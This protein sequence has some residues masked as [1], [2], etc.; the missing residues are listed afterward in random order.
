MNGLEDEVVSSVSCGARHTIAV[1]EDGEAFTWGLGHFGAL[2]RSFTPF[3]YDA[4]TAVVAF[5]GADEVI[6][7]AGFQDAVRPPINVELQETPRNR[8][9]ELAAH[10]DLIANLSLDDSSNQCIP[11]K[12]DSLDGIKI[13]GS[14]AGHRHSLLLSADGALYSFGTGKNGCLGHGDTQSQMFPMRIASFDEEGVKI[15]QMSAGVDNSMAV[16]TNGNCYAWGKS[17]GG[18][19]GLRY[20]GN[21]TYPRRVTI[22]SPS[23]SAIKAVDVECGYV[24]AVIVGLNGTLHMCGGVG[25]DGAAD[26]QVQDN[27]NDEIGPPRQVPDFNVWHRQ[28]E[29]MESSEKKE[30]WQK[31]GKYEVKGRT[32]AMQEPVSSLT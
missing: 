7:P 5:A 9:A 19:I 11:K 22:S 4:D 15:M 31:L 14:S 26:G 27:E 21:V 30:R 3:D 28:A 17:D 12:V 2:G 16:A 20:E 25:L 24:H 13:V 32:K 8:D 18:R 6:P 10:L 23:G 29:P 1:T